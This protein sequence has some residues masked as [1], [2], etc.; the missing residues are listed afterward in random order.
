M[1]LETSGCLV[2]VVSGKW[3]RDTV[4]IYKIRD[5]PSRIAGSISNCLRST[6][7]VKDYVVC[8]RIN[9]SL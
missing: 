1:K 2:Y 8:A 9:D 3:A 4:S 7:L 6:L 5:N